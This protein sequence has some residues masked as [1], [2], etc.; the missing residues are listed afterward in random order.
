MAYNAETD[1]FYLFT[2]QETDLV[3]VDMAESD[4]LDAL[5]DDYLLDK[6][7]IILEE[8]TDTRNKVFKYA[9]AGEEFSIQRMN[10]VEFS[11]DA[12]YD[13]VRDDF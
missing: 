3:R 9:R 8:D 5:T 12:D 11:F 13:E 7:E 2:L 10:K 6:A 4:N 1:K